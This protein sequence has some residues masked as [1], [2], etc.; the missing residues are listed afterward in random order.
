MTPTKEQIEAA[1]TWL[2]EQNLSGSQ[3]LY[4]MVHLVA[5]YAAHR[6]AEK[7][8]EIA[9]LKEALRPFSFV[10]KE[11]DDVFET[12]IDANT[13]LI[14][15]CGHDIWGVYVRDFLKARAALQETTP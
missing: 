6:T 3:A 11:I 8:A 10:A 7:D 9:R 1:R 15:V 14:T 12:V 13:A 4:H 5:E 2:R